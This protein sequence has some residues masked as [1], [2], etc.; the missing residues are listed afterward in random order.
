MINEAKHFIDFKLGEYKLSDFNGFRYNEDEK[1]VYYGLPSVKHITQD[2]DNIDGSLYIKSKHETRILEIPIFIYDNID[3]NRFKSWVGDIESGERELRFIYENGQLSEEYINVVYNSSYDFTTWYHN[4]FN[5]KAKLSFIAHNP[6]YKI[7]NES[8]FIINNP[9]IEQ[10]YTF[11]SKGNVCS[12]PRIEIT[13]KSKTNISLII[14][15]LPITILNV[16]KTIYIN[17]NDGEVYVLNNGI[18]QTKYKDYKSNGNSSLPI[19]Y[20]YQKPNSI[21]VMSGDIYD[22]KIYPN[23]LII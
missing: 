23:S 2:N 6:Y 11:K 9:L 13:P 7:K 22:I 20:P 14:N 12:N 21:K 18:R 16:D 4:G 5:G 8:P 17:S 15:E 19:V 3:M 1:I 10:I